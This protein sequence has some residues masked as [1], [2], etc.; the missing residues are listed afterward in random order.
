LRLQLGDH[1][2]LLTEGERAIRLA[3][4]SPKGVTLAVTSMS[5]PQAVAAGNR[6]RVIGEKVWLRERETTPA[7]TAPSQT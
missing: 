2:L 3:I 6:I 7:R 4:I 1:E 5:G